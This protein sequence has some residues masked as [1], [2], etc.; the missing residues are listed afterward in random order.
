MQEKDLSDLNLLW[1]PLRPFL[2][3]QITELYGR[4]DG[5]I[6]E[7][8]PFSGLIFAFAQQ[9]LGDSFAVAAFP[10]NTVDLLKREA[11]LLN[12]TG[13][14]K[15]IGS[16]PSLKN[17]P[18]NSAD[19]IVFRGA[20]FFPS[21]FRTDFLAIHRVLRPKGLAFVGGGFGKY[22]PPPLIQQMGE[23]SRDLNLAMGKINVEPEQIRIALDR[24]GL[25][26]KAEVI[27]DG[28]LWVLIRK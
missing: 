2:V 23:R 19:L 1:E 8:G 28:G 26:A 21:L 27:T 22:T 11:G 5:H 10:E 17:I 18:E 7:M 25:G 9:H 24:I 16:D 4:T 15:V 13:S 12:L 3:Q 14:V 20:L 6:L